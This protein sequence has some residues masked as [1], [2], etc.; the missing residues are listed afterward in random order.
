[1]EQQQQQP[2]QPQDAAF[3]AYEEARPKREALARRCLLG[4][5]RTPS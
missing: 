4:F 1:M 3:R 2:Q 5:L